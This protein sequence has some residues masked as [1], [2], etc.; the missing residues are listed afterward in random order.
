MFGSGV[1]EGDSAS[2]C[3]MNLVQDDDQVHTVRCKDA[4]GRP[5][6]KIMSCNEL[7]KYVL[8]FSFL[9]NVLP[10]FYILT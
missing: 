9:D 5:P 3:S 4:E 6:F 1:S 7:C 2:I 10:F 8:V